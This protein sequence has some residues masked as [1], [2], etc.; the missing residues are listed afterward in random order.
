MNVKKI[1]TLILVATGIYIGVVMP[2]YN[3]DVIKT[4]SRSINK[5]PDW[6]YWAK[7]SDCFVIAEKENP[8]WINW[9]VDESYQVENPR[10]WVDP[11]N[12]GDGR[13]FWLYFSKEFYTTWRQYV[14]ATEN[15]NPEL[16][17]FARMKIY[18]DGFDYAWYTDNS[19]NDDYNFSTF[20]F[21]YDGV[22]DVYYTHLDNLVGTS[23]KIQMD[24]NPNWNLDLYKMQI[25]RT[26]IFEGFNDYIP[27]NRPIEVESDIEL[28]E[29]ST[30]NNNIV[31]GDT[32]NL[33]VTLNNPKGFKFQSIVID[34]DEYSVNSSE[35]ENQIGDEYRIK[36]PFT[37]NTKYGEI[38]HTV[39]K[40]VM[41]AP[42]GLDYDVVPINQ[43]SIF[44]S[45]DSFIGGVD[46]INVFLDKTDVKFTDPLIVTITLDNPDSIKLNGVSI[47]E[48][49]YNNITKSTE[50]INDVFGSSD[51]YSNHDYSL[52]LIDNIIELADEIS[53]NYWIIKYAENDY[54]VYYLDDT[55]YYLMNYASKLR[56]S[57]SSGSSKVEGYLADYDPNTNQLINTRA[58]T[59][60]FEMAFTTFDTLVYY[61]SR[62]YGDGFP[63]MEEYATYYQKA[64]T[65][66]SIDMIT[67]YLEGNVPFDID[68][69][70]FE[71]EIDDKIFKEKKTIDQRF[72]VNIENPIDISNITVDEFT[73]DKSIAFSDETIKGTL[74]ITNP[75][76]LKLEYIYINNNLVPLFENVNSDMNNLYSFDLALCDYFY[77]DLNQLFISKL[78]FSGLYNTNTINHDLVPTGILANITIVDSHFAD[79]VEITS[80]SLDKSYY[81][82]DDEMLVTLN[83]NN[84]NNVNI[85]S[86]NVNDVPYNLSKNSDSIYKFTIPVKNTG[87]GNVVDIIQSMK[88]EKNSL[89]KENV[90]NKNINY[91]LYTSSDV[92]DINV[93]NYKANSDFIY[94]Y[95]DDHF[96]NITLSNT[97]NLVPRSVTINNHEYTD[98][99][100]DEETNGIKIPIKAVTDVKTESINLELEKMT[101][102]NGSEIAT[103]TINNNLI[104]PVANTYQQRVDEITENH[105]L[106]GFNNL[107]FLTIVNPLLSYVFP[108]IDSM[109]INYPT[110]MKT[111]SYITL[112]F[113]CMLVTYF[114]FRNEFQRINVFKKFKR[115]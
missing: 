46:N 92:A 32:Y 3:H 79:N 97:T 104:L 71:K 100:F 69:L 48:K 78:V 74:K 4:E 108:F 77:A 53:I 58:I 36:I 102:V 7:C 29:I 30:D 11:V 113:S 55:S 89:M 12:L 72:N 76:K 2:S 33:F 17:A 52:G 90:F 27:Y 93:L 65:V 54:K 109:S 16:K 14:L 85:L 21:E 13:D 19:R 86:V 80:V 50:E 20:D 84:P 82:Y 39:E 47:N 44:Y 43:S 101:F 25:Q 110:V 5:L 37:N 8:F 106:N 73:I 15:A 61:T 42:N 66:Y 18:S 96:V 95:R 68:Y 31:Y 34:G 56:F 98:F 103:K 41:K 105:K 45:A 99:D 111:V 67:P 57:T 22:N 6:Q 1:I 28:L 70:L 38:Y 81:L 23:V 60:Y 83:I 62:T 59:D 94:L 10:M 24:Y 40:I 107:I 63:T 91:E 87:F 75:D 35:T 64:K 49:I 115:K 112:I 51:K 114:M 88:F 26:G 9:G